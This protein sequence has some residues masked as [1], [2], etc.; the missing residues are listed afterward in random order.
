MDLGTARTR[1][2]TSALLWASSTVHLWVLQPKKFA[3]SFGL[4]RP[5]EKGG[6]YA[7]QRAP[8][9]GRRVGATV[10]KPLGTV[11]INVGCS[12]GDSVRG[13]L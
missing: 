12:D 9:V 3:A 10:G 11:G 1:G 6:S 2:E 13:I 4:S 7:R 8:L 5:A